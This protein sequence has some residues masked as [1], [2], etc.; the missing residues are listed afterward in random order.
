MSI[1][2]DSYSDPLPSGLEPIATDGHSFAHGPL[3][4]RIGEK[5]AA[6]LT[7]RQKGTANE[8]TA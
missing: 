6:M 5:S 7:A 1:E 2:R 3:A 4:D 8:D